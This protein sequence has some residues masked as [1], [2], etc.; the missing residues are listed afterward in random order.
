MNTANQISTAECLVKLGEYEQAIQIYAELQ[1]AE[2]KNVEY[3]T[4]MQQLF[5]MRLKNHD[6][7][8]ALHMQEFAPPPPPVAVKPAA[9]VMLPM[10]PMPIP[11]QVK[12]M[13]PVA[14]PQPPAPTP[15]LF[16]SLR[17]PQYPKAAANVKLESVL[18]LQKPPAPVAKMA[19]APPIVKLKGRGKAKMTEE[20]TPGMNAEV[21]AF[22]RATLEVQEGNIT[23]ESNALK[24]EIKETQKMISQLTGEP[25][26]PG[27]KRKE[28]AASDSE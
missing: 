14:M 18:A 5:D 21:E 28:A 9:R 17:L 13:P 2:P 24:K 8:A 25:I 7:Q 6:V 22:W 20:P 26:A 12:P 1:E 27:R 19:M 4:R 16:A 3:D 10:P 15:Q 11:K 23:R